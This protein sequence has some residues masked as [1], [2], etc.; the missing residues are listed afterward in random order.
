MP[1]FGN[2]RRFGSVASRKICVGGRM[3][4]SAWDT[5]ASHNFISTRLAAELISKGVLWRRCELPIRQ[6]VIPAGVSRIK[7][8]ASLDI[9]HRGRHLSLTDEIFWVWDMGP[10]V[11][12]CNAFLEDEDLLPSSAG[13]S[14]DDLLS[15]FVTQTGPFT[16]GE[17]EDLLLS[18]LQSRSNYSRTALVEVANLS[19]VAQAGP[20]LPDELTDTTLYD[21]AVKSFANS[22]ARQTT[23]ARVDAW[24]LST[25][26][27]ARKLLI[28][29]LNN[30]DVDCKRRLEEIKA[31]YP[32]AFGDT[33]REPCKLRK[34]EILLKP[35]FKY[36]CFL[37][38]RVSE[39]VMAEMR[40]QINAL[41]E[42]GVIENC[43]DSPFAFP[44]VMA[45]RPNSD[46][47]RLCCDYKLQN[48]QT[49]PSP[50]PVPDLRGQLDRLAGKAYYCS[51]DC[52]Q[53]FHQFELDEASRYLTA[54]VVPW[55]EKFQW[56]R[57][58]F[59]LR[60]C[61]AHCQQE[62]SQLL[63]KSGIRCLQDI[64]PY[65]D[66]VA[67]G[68][69]S[70]D[71]LC[72]K[73]EELCKLAVQH[74]LR[75]K[76]SKCVL[77]ATAISHLGFVVN[78]EGIHIAPSRVDSLLKL[79]AAKS[80][81]DV[82]HI[83]GSFVFCREWLTDMT[84]MT[85]P[86]TDLLKKGAKWEWG[87]AQDRALRL[88]KEGVV[89]G[90]CLLGTID[91]TKKV[92][93]RSD[94]S[95]LG[96]A[97]V[98]FQFVANSAGELKA[99]AI[100]Y[101]SRR[102][103]ATEFK[104]I[105]NEKEAYSIKFIFEKF[106]DI[107]K[108]HEIVCQTDHRNSLWIQS[109]KSPKVIRWRLFLNQWT[110]TIEHLPGKMNE[111]ADGLSRIQEMSDDELDKLISRL[112]VSNLFETSPDDSARVGE[113]D[114][115]T[116]DLDI[117][118]AMFNGVIQEALHELH[119]RE[120]QSVAPHVPAMATIASVMGSM[121]FDANPVESS[122]AV[123]TE[124]GEEGAAMLNAIS[125][126]LR[127]KLEKVHSDTAGHVGALRTYRRLRLLPDL[128]EDMTY[129]R[130]MQEC[131]EFVR[132]CPNCQKM[133]S[134]P[135]PWKDAHFR[136]IRA[137]PFR[138]ISID[139][140]EMPYADLDGNLKAF[141][142]IDSFSRALELF[143]LP[144]ADAPRVAEALY[145]VYC[146]FGRFSV[147][148]IDGAKAFVGSVLPLLM[149]LLGST[150][151]Q[152]HAFAHWEN[153]QIERA[154]K[155]V[156]RHLRPLIL[157]DRA[158]AN[159]QRRWNTLLNGARRIL[160]NTV[161]CSTGVAPNALIYGGFADREEELFTCSA[162]Q[163]CASDDIPSF[164]QEL[165]QEQSAL[166][167]R[168]VDFQ[169]LEFD[170]IVAKAE[171]SPDDPL[172]QGT[173]VLANREGMPHGRPVDKFQCRRTGPW[174]VLERPDPVH[175]VVQCVHA[176]DG[177]VVSFH[178]TELVPFNC[179]L[180]DSPEDYAR[181]AQRDFWEYSIDCISAHR[182]LLPRRQRGCRLR[183]KSSY[184]FLVHYKFLPLSDED[185]CENPCWQP[186][187]NV[188]HLAALQLYCNL[189]QVQAQLGSDFFVPSP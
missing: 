185:G 61:P 63:I 19:S 145:A 83:L 69:D 126:E 103:S 127:P 130:L 6:G 72:E 167:Q 51:L 12:L 143:P 147:V 123:W 65:L 164:V 53:F 138:E 22:V 113:V 169:Q 43:P 174:R 180:M 74:G 1:D 177:R 136:W 159:S 104:W 29:Q 129:S 184:E 37:P 88:L 84:S 77:G 122:L 98:I 96:V 55:G 9:V 78:K 137:P 112:H 144:A 73:F 139:V 8:L 38:R 153:G 187:H 100:A 5:Y 108:G 128:P 121:D 179:D 168:A 186:F 16:V 90:D 56:K 135:S 81:D 3:I 110:H 156:L 2:V 66:D 95:I 68:A 20:P 97:C 111:T 7:L 11:T 85:A 44:I 57:A 92:Y 47:L 91:V 131:S 71:E 182:P 101:S 36:Y 107:L 183:A 93:A 124:V 142:V 154:H 146:R 25:I 59:G 14:D 148:R 118:T 189:P 94:S 62:F 120:E 23:Q 82:R 33:I 32:E 21:D 35:G 158:G 155:E 160:M 15:A 119:I 117:D 134:L 176:A 50:F 42:Q 115:E 173:W 76:E 172:L 45:R 34:F 181:H 151:H 40:K 99:K 52:S 89:T 70:I 39:P 106:G 64:Q 46:K 24:S 49:I 133:S 109:S 157:S 80:V 13:D 175:P 27:E 54:F 140:L 170:R 132:A 60:N 67:F 18:H 188:Q 48:D 171:K 41:L 28:Q 102:Y 141:A 125:T 26:L 114:D 58:P 87:P 152:I 149:T 10:D 105:L 116:T 150:C 79:P 17:G 86:L 178:R 30:P 163:V 4:Q 161:N 162:D 31:R 165:E 166:M 75:F